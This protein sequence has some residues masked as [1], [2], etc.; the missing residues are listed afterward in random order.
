LAVAVAAELA[1]HPAVEER[2][3]SFTKAVTGFP[4]LEPTKSRWDPVELQ[5]LT[6]EIRQ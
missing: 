5:M 3:G 4:V 6:E 2:A 1:E